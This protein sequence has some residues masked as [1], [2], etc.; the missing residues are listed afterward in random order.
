MIKVLDSLSFTRTIN[1]DFYSSSGVEKYLVKKFMP[2]ISFE[3]TTPERKVM[4]EKVDQ[5][6]LPTVEGE[7]TVLANH[8]P[9]VAMLVP[10][11][12]TLVNDGKETYLSVS[13]GFIEVRPGSRVVVLA[14]TAE[15]A[16]ELDEKKVEEARE[17]AKKILEEKRHVDDT[18]FADA[19]AVM[20]RELARLKVIR[21]KSHGSS[22]KHTESN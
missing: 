4:E 9:L 6:T 5:I 10:G 16:E 13:G 14:D 22:S 19:A 2:K 12:V 18:A 15:R 3:L 17:R 7:I 8:I 21:K 11:M 1:F 20:A